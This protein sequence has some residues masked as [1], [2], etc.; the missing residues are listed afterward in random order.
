[1]EEEKNGLRIV[2]K[3]ENKESSKRPMLTKW[4]FSNLFVIVMDFSTLVKMKKKK[5]TSPQSWI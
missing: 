2:E 5:T 1:M 4:D 3:K